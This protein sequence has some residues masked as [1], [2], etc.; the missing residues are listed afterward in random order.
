MNLRE[1]LHAANIEGAFNSQVGAVRV[2]L[3]TEE[4]KVEIKRAML[5]DGDILLVPERHIF[6]AVPRDAG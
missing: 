5:Q 2:V 6:A 1:L 3:L 4:G